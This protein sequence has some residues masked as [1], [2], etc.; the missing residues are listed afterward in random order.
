MDALNRSL[1]ELLRDLAQPLAEQDLEGGWT[2]EKRDRWRRDLEGLKND[3]ESGGTPNGAQH[4]LGRALDMD[5]IFAGPLA[6]RIVRLQLK[7]H[8]LFAR[9][10]PRPAA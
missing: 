9:H 3:L 10:P 7:L 5:E 2:D 4:H 1:D 6:D 8:R